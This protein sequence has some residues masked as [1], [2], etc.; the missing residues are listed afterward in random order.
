MT[1]LRISR[2][3]AFSACITACLALVALWANSY[4][5]RDTLYRWRSNQYVHLRSW[6]GQISLSI[7]PTLHGV[8]TKDK[9]RLNHVSTGQFIEELR[10]TGDAL[11]EPSDFLGFSYTAQRSIGHELRVPHWFLVAL[12]AVCAVMLKPPPRRKFSLRELIGILT[13]AAISTAAFVE[14][15][16]LLQ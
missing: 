9:I 16:R 6:R 7:S 8:A 5:Y 3:L 1:M 10:E 13:F 2:I 11:A 4:F 15:V 12:G 14:A